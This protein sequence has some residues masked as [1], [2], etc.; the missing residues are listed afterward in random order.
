M[1]EIPGFP[2]GKT[3][4]VGII[5]AGPAGTFTA[6]NFLRLAREKGV[7]IR[8]VLFDRKEFHAV[9]PR[10]CNMCA[11]AIGYLTYEK[12][13]SIGL[14]LD[15]RV[16][17]RIADGYVFHGMKN[18]ARIYHP[19]RTGIYTVFRG[20]G[21]V[22]MTSPSYQS[23]DR[24]LLD[25]CLKM[26]AQFVN[27]RVTAIEREDGEFPPRYTVVVEGGQR[28]SFNFLVGAFGVNTTIS[29]KFLP[30]YQPPRTWH[31]CQAEIEVPSGYIER[32]M[33][34]MIHL[35]STLDR[36][37]RFLAVT[38]KDRFLTITAIGEHVKIAYLREELRANPVVRRFLPADYEILCHCHPQ[39]PV[40]CARNPVTQ[41]A[42]VVGDAFTA[43]YLKN[44][45]DSAFDTAMTLVNAVFS[46]G[47]SK[48]AL[49]KLYVRPSVEK[50]H[51]DNR[52]GKILFQ[53]YERILRKRALSEAY[54]RGVKKEGEDASREDATL[55]RV[56][57]GIFAGDQPYSE[58]MREALNPKTVLNFLKMLVIP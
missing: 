53:V 52:F 4:N 6:L 22:M 43:R 21:P 27:A 41:A 58:I 13:R 19:Q 32:V 51:R 39:T 47:I 40:G 26:G 8:V 14:S 30:A 28:E 38:P 10:G 44:G 50:I 24:F 45:I 34:N 2:R 37:I 48:A 18:E 15:E 57:W 33:G 29:R 3:F 16:V 46:G 54:I 20:G 7:P 35:F 56:L 17:R 11:G 55:T 25:E 9:G 49:E 1:S 12:I 36:K 42:A 31:T 5:G 23:F